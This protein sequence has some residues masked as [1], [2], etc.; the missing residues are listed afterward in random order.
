[1]SGIV[2]IYGEWN[3]EIMKE[4]GPLNQQYNTHLALW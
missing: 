4:Q 1:M 2:V 3:H